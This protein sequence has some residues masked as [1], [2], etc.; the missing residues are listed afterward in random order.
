MLFTQPKKILLTKNKLQNNFDRRILPT[1][2][3]IM[4]KILILFTIFLECF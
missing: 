2:L 3:F 1:N 4:L